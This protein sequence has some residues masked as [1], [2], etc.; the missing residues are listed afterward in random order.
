MMC[1][2]NSFS[3]S[4]VYFCLIVYVF[5]SYCHKLAELQTSK[6]S[7]WNNGPLFSQKMGRLMLLHVDSK[8]PLIS[9]GCLPDM[10]EWGWVLDDTLARAVMGS[11]PCSPP[12][13]ISRWTMSCSS[14]S[15]CRN[16]WEHIS[17]SGALLVSTLPTPHCPNKLFG[18]TQN[19]GRG[20]H[21]T[22]G[23]DSE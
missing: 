3:L 10:M 21:Y 20:I 17:H 4:Y 7:T 19:Q 14:S 11:V 22:Y 1:L 23:S 2:T 16:S 13:G 18:Y 15:D 9:P 8:A 5:F 6:Y 12:P